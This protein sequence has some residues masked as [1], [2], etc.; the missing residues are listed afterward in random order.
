M[1]DDY[2]FI[3]PLLVERINA[4]VPGLKAVLTAT[5]MAEILETRQITPAVHVVYL[6]DG[7]PAGPAKATRVTQMWAAVVAVHHADPKG[8]GAGARRIA[9]P[10]IAKL[11]RALS[12]WVPHPIV[13]PLERSTPIPSRFSNGYGY[14]PFVF[15][16]QFVFK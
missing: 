5:E 1:V 2:L 4:E 9:G 12:G 10:L 3:E 15:R 6:G 7:K 16:A 8:D 11:L 13:T 14:Y